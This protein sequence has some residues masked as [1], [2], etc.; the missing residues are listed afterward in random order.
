MS[1][2]SPS[3]MAKSEVVVIW[4]TNAAATVN[5]MTHATRARKNM[6]AKIVAIDIYPTETMRQADLALQLGAR[7]RWGAR[8]RCDARALPRRPSR[9]RLRDALPRTRPRSSK[10]TF[11][12]VR[13]YGRAPS[14]GSGW[15]R[16]RL[17]AA[18][19]RATWRTFFRLGYGLYYRASATARRTCTPRS[20]SPR[21]PAWARRRQR[22]A[23]L[24]AVY[25]LDGTLIQGL[26]A[27][28]A[29]VRR[30]DQSRV[31]AYPDRRP[32]GALK[33]AAQLRR[34]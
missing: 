9:P 34:C 21:S 18:L 30:L 4:G 24:S 17:L 19:V 31:G 14:R 10:P 3:E 28:D 25:K 11:A 32:Q 26:D 20:Q 27:C 16:S 5:L 8:L 6:V 23:R 22:A 15:R 2:V 33:G 1:G 29:S 12:T 13:L 7:N